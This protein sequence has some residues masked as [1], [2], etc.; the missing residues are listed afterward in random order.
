RDQQ[1]IETRLNESLRVEEFDFTPLIAEPSR[2]RSYR[3]SQ[4][5]ELP[6]RT[7]VDNNAHPLYTILEIQ[8]PDRLGLLYSLLRALGNAG[9][10]IQNSRITTEMD[11]A[12]DTFYVT[13]RLDAKIQEEAAIERLQRLLQKASARPS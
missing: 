7:V 4:D 2:L 8:T 9:I 3:L 10:S 6:S 1:R 12:M 5:A 13:D 11:V